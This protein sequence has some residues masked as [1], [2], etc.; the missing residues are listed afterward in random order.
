MQK[1]IYPKKSLSGTITVPGDKS[2]SHRA[3]M[4]G[5]I[6]EGTTEISG[7]L[8]GDD[9]M[10]TISC[11]K[12]LGIDIEVSGDNVTVHGKGLNGLSKPTEMLDAGNSGTTIRLI[13]GILAAQ[14]FPA[15]LQEMHQF[16]KDL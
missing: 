6:A 16:K 1:V 10:S 5:A 8:T 9:C 13:S 12:K 3:V 11:F 15:K 7:F 4:F 2:I 14:P